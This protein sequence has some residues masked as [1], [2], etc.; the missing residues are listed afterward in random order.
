MNIFLCGFM[1]CGKST[2]GK[3]LSEKLDTRFIDLDEYIVEKEGRTI[4]EIFSADG[5]DYFRKKEAEC[6]KELSQNGGIIA[7]GGGAIL[8]EDTARLANSCGKVVFIDVPFEICYERIKDDQNRPLVQKNTMD[9]LFAL[10]LKRR[11]IYKKNS[12]FCVDGNGSA[13]EVAFK[14]SELL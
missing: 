1:G 12:A 3:I 4:P 13:A 2:I 6:L 11:P 5:E 8:N 10:Y 14:I 7:T 9:E